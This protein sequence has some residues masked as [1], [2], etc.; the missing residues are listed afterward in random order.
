MPPF[1]TVIFDLDGTLLNTLEDLADSTNYA[2]AAHHMPQRTLDEVRRF[3]GNGVALLIH[4]AV[5]QGTPPETEEAVLSCFRAHY[6]GNME[7]KTAPYAGIPA[8][9]SS[10][11]EAG[12]SLAVV[13]NKF[14]GA[15]KG[16]CEK[17]FGPVLPVAVGESP[18]VAKKP[19]A[20]MVHLALRALGRDG[21]RAVYVGDSDVDIATAQNA[22]LPCISVTW[23]FRDEEFL[24]AHGAQHIVHTPQQLEALLLP[25]QGRTPPL[26]GAPEASG[27]CEKIPLCP[28]HRRALCRKN[29]EIPCPG[30]ITLTKGPLH[31]V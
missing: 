9:L 8:L 13:S 21:G 5:P 29:A 1:D 24:R 10:L 27:L 17:Y 6:L 23:G 2:L 30:K 28:R 26:A 25:A 4:R 22:A 16:L 11:S 20:D 18:G 7:H 15:V 12:L 14:D 3:V 31:P 19:A